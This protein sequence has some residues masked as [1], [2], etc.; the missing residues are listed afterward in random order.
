MTRQVCTCRTMPSSVF[1]VCRHPRPC[2]CDPEKNSVC[3]PTLLLNLYPTSATMTMACGRVQVDLEGEDSLE[4]TAAAIR[5]INS[6]ATI[7]RTQRCVVDVG[8][9]L[10][11]GAYSERGIV[12]VDHDSSSAALRP[13]DVAAAQHAAPES[14]PAA[15][16]PSTAG[17]RSASAA[18]GRKRH[19]E[20]HSGDEADQQL[21][22]GAGHGG[23]LH[24][25]RVT[26]TTLHCQRPVTLDRCVRDLPYLRTRR[27][28]PTRSTS[29]AQC[30]VCTE[31][32]V[33]CP[34]GPTEV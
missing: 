19:A 27:H 34:V 10:N 1:R 5:G 12:S 11:Q 9:L 16:G 31:S 4:A 7:V 6:S 28:M 25:R 8:R 2:Q 14:A 29:W 22:L 24:A 20:E 17:E 30:R 32:Y 15:D 13:S 23:H 21:A 3:N 18:N 26:S 33:A